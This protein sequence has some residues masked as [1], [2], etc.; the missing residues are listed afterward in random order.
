MRWVL[1][2]V[3]LLVTC[4]RADELPTLESLQQLKASKQW[5]ELLK[6]TSRL[7]ALKGKQA[8]GVDRSAVWILKA[9][10]QLQSNQFVPAAESFVE[11]SEEPQTAP[12]RADFAYA[13]SLVCR[14]SDAR[15]FRAPATRKNPSPP[16]FAIADESVR[17]DAIGALLA[18]ELV[19]CHERLTGIKASLPIT[20][21]GRL[22]ADA[23]GL[24]R[25]ERA[26]SG[27]T[28]QSDKL[29][30][31]ITRHAGITTREW[32]TKTSDELDKIEQ[33]AAEEQKDEKGRSRPRGLTPGDRKK[34][35]E[36]QAKLREIAKDYQS[37]EAK[38]GDQADGS[39]KE[40]PQ[41]LEGVFKQAER[42]LDRNYLRATR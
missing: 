5:A 6:G 29:I 22:C 41:T 2:I 31:E 34:V 36:M 15:G 9:E 17:K 21:M 24:R 30:V 23:V 12:D 14:K 8:E 37:L 42:V 4:V 10:A 33:A 38:V 26:A 16:T 11:A 13:M 25:V 7:L 20:A 1:P 35:Q 28:E 40:L 32:C 27:G 39:F 19:E 18:S 3:L